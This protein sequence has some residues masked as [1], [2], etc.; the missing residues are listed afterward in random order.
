MRAWDKNRRLIS[1]RSDY[2]RSAYIIT[3]IC[4]TVCTTTSQKFSKICLHLYV[5]LLTCQKYHASNP[6]GGRICAV[7]RAI[8]GSGMASRRKTNQ[9]TCTSA[10][11]EAFARERDDTH[12]ARTTECCAD[13][14]VLRASNTRQWRRDAQVAEGYLPE[15]RVR[16]ELSQC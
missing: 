4:I 14:R 1:S 3:V 15:G 16:T 8:R 5:P 7:D 13:A 2:C 6:F 10:P 11:A 9:T 12:L